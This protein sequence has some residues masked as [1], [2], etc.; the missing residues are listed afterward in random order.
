MKLL[1][2]AWIAIVMEGVA[3]IAILADTLGIELQ[4]F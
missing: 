4:R 3:E 1:F 2:N